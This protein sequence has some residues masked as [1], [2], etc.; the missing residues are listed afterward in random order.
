MIKSL[1]IKTSIV[2]NFM[3]VGTPINVANAEIET[4]PLTAE[5]KEI[6]ENA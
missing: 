1:E 6:Q 5:T 4:Q 3:P 2:V